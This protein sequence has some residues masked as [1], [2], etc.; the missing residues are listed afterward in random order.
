MIHN[1]NLVS[2]Q[3]KLNKMKD[4]AIWKS[5]L[6]E[7]GS[8]PVIEYLFPNLQKIFLLDCVNKDI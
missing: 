5:M 1:G 8:R 4:R 7:I 6:Y 2:T 3:Q